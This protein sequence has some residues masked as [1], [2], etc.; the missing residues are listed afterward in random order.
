VTDGPLLV[1]IGVELLAG[2]PVG[3]GSYDASGI[4]AVAVAVAVAMA[5]GIGVIVGTAVAVG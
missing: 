1:G 3:T 2:W 5:E 4:Y